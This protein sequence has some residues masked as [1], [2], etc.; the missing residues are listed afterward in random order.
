MPERRT[1]VIAR[2]PGRAARRARGLGTPS[3]TPPPLL[4]APEGAR[5]SMGF[6][7]QG[8]LLA[9]IGPPSGE[10]CPPGVAHVSFARSPVERT[11]AAVFRASIPTPS[12]FRPQTLAGPRA[13]AFLGF[14]PP[15]HSPPPPSRA[16]LDARTVPPHA[17]G[18]MTSRPACVSRYCG[19]EGRLAPLGATGSP[20]FLHLPTV[21][22]PQG[23]PRGA[24]SSL[25]LRACALA[26]ARTPLNPLA[27]GP[28]GAS[29]GPA[30]PSFGER[31]R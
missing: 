13:D 19:R 15:E 20:G 18:G 30:P 24:G 16:F 26:G 9:P 29:P 6:T 14:I 23:P 5:A 11:D 25:R 3:A 17:L 2:P 31:L 21:V 4:R 10:P 12:S 22:A 8:L 28:T 27:C 7:L 1:R